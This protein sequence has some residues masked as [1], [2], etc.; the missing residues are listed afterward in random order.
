MKKNTVL[1][2]H[3]V[4]KLLVAIVLVLCS[5]STYAISVTFR[6][7]MAY[8]IKNGTFHP[9]TDKVYV[10]G[11]FNSWTLSNPM[12]QESAG[13]YSTTL[14]LSSSTWYEFK[15]F[16]DAAGF[17]NSGWEANVGA[18]RDNRIMSIVKNE[19]VDLG[20]V[21][22]NN[23]NLELRKSGSYYDF[24]CADPD[25][26]YIG[27]YAS[28]LDENVPRIVNVLETTLTSKVK[29]WIYPDRKSFM[30]AYGSPV[31]PDWVGGTAFGHSDLV[32]L[33]PRIYSGGKID[34]GLVGHEFAHAIVDCKKHSYV[35]AWL[36]EGAACYYGGEPAAIGLRMDGQIRDLLNNKYHGVKP[37]L[38]SIE[39][40][41]FA[42]ND[43]YPLSTSI[44]DFIINSFGSSKFAQFIVDTD[45]S[46]LGF[47]SKSE[48]Q[49][50]WH[51][52]LDDVYLP[53]TPFVHLKIDM[54]YYISKGW[55]NPATDK[56][57]IGGPFTSWFPYLL[58]NQSNGIYSYTL[59]CVENKSY[60]YKFKISTAGAANGGWE[61]NVGTG[62]NGDRVLQPTTVDQTLPTAM[63]NNTN[64]TLSL[65]SPNGNESFIAGDT[66]S[67]QWKFSTIP[68]IKIEYTTDNGANWSLISASV[69]TANLSINWKVPNTVA[70]SAKVRITDTSNPSVNNVSDQSFSIVE[71]NEVGGPFLPDDHTMALLHFENN[72]MNSSPHTG[73][74]ILYG[75]GSAFENNSPLKSG[76][77][78]NLD[79]DDYVTIPHSQAL[80]LIGDWTLE[81]W[82]KLNEYTEGPYLFYKPGDNDTYL[83]NYSLQIASWWDNVIFGF[84][85]SQNSTRIGLSVPKPELN[86]W[87][88]IAY[89]RDTQK[90]QLKLLLHD[91]NFNLVSSQT[92]SYTETG[93][94]I[95]S[96][97]LEIGRGFKG[98]MDELRISNSIREFRTI[99]ITTPNGGETLVGGSKANIT[100]NC[101]DIANVNLEYSANNGSTWVSVA[102]NLDA[103]TRSYIWTV[104][105]TAAISCKIRIS[106]ANDTTLY[107]DSD[108][109][110]T[111]SNAV[112]LAL[113]KPTGGES[114]KTGSTQT[115]TWNAEGITTCKLEYS[116][117]NGESWQPIS[118][119]I[120]AANRSYSFNVPDVVAYEWKFKISDA[121]N[122]EI[123]SISDGLVVSYN[124]LPQSVPPL[125]SIE[126]PVFNWPLNAYYPPTIPTDNQ[127]INGNVGNACGPTVVANLLRYWEF[128][129]KGTGSRT[130]TDALGCN[131]TADFKN[132]EYKYDRMPK[133]VPYAAVQAEYDAVATLM[134]HSGVAMHN[135]FRSG[136]R[137]GVIDAMENYF[138][139][140]KKAKFLSREDYTPEQWEKI[141]KSE[142]SLGRPLITEGW[143]NIQPNGNHDGHWFFCDGYNAENLYHVKWDYGENSNEYCPLYKFGVY[144]AYNWM[145]VYLE[146]DLKGKKLELTTP[147]GNE[148]W[149]QGTQKTIMW[150]SSNVN[151]LNIEFST[152]NGYDWK[153]L[154]SNVST[155]NGSYT[156]TVPAGISNNC[157]IRITDASDMNI[158]D[159]N[160]ISFSVLDVRDLAFVQSFPAQLQ[161]GCTIPLRWNSKGV[162]QV[163]IDYS[164]NSGSSWTKI[165]DTL[166]TAETYLWKVPDVVSSTCLIKVS[167]KMDNTLHATSDAFSIGDETLTG[168]PFC[169]TENTVALLHFNDNYKNEAIFSEDGLYFNTVSF[170]ENFDLGLDKCIKIDN[171]SSSVFSNIEIPHYEALSL[172]KGWNIELWFKLL[173]WGS[174]SVEYPTLL[175]KPGANYYISPLPNGKKLMAG[176]DYNEGNE[177]VILPNNSVSLNTWYH[178]TF[179]KNPET[180]TLELILHDS[181]LKQVAYATKQYNP[182]H[183]PNTSNDPLR[184]GGFHMGSNCQLNGYVDEVIISRIVEQQDELTV[185]F[186]VDMNYQIT[187]GI[188]NPATDKVYLKGSFNGWSEQNQ[189]LENSGTGV[190]T[191]TITLDPS[192]TY[193]YKYFITSSG[194]ENNGWELNVGTE[195]NSNRV[196]LTGT[197]S[198][199]LATNYFNNMSVS[200]KEY[201]C[202]VS[203]ECYPNPFNNSTTIRFELPK[204]AK[205]TL[206]VYTIF[207][208]LIATLVDEELPAGTHLLEWHA[209][210]LPKGVYYCRLQGGAFT[211]GQKMVFLGG[212]GN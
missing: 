36:N 141:V 185:T 212:N 132:T 171:S 28:Y 128:P 59:P 146:P 207:G 92:L 72:L 209:S 124:D 48:F 44:A 10:G 46:V 201:S 129:R 13:V 3:L 84:Y 12:D 15:F 206:N 45:Y 194:A 161:S 202:N 162:Q 56:V 125:M 153:T 211:A 57:Y 199:E 16:T 83:S 183:I 102:T 93:T 30:L 188:F 189:M 31:G 165:A 1:T 105:S 136:D 148:N 187:N 60:E 18:G 208:K 107:D 109:L 133:S 159:R 63:Y 158:Y 77:S 50:A 65:V 70:S 35:H 86:K 4:Q 166:A 2:A 178:V 137:S 34:E 91:E 179:I 51:K 14:T 23:G 152:N 167:D 181:Q 95:N 205:T 85:F 168:G 169:L 54:G 104:P 24:Y 62:T 174:G 164:T 101:T 26:Q 9:A 99:K 69:N 198:T 170:E 122:P 138:N 94:L 25:T 21:Y 61:E 43:G 87:Y 155:A 157:K 96:K 143:S 210:S 74:G 177:Q 192:T 175:L 71:P 135:Y 97:P 112:T 106:D 58:A 8:Q 140:S 103:K 33:S 38:S 113:T 156:V 29:I 147:A 41:S 163:T 184:I 52:F 120:Q 19:D 53:P 20:K 17:P 119:S 5:L 200:V 149:Q 130:F 182:S 80:N 176:Y 173:S 145:Y 195:G 32:I 108:Q 193:E 151:S 75:Q 37:E 118:N 42:D 123:S 6:V 81:T 100:W 55:F 73:Y 7:D 172:K 131:W 89:I 68:A 110:F 134:Y 64:P 154:A 186:S 22:F 190:Y 79:G 88:H 66:V 117:D 139:Y 114:W 121:S 78:F 204:A 40:W 76:Y 27:R 11:T 196:V 39:S 47:A 203:L 90:S 150:S 49:A 197:T 191:C 67:I 116:T 160:T 111:I 98:Y 144:A 127:I 82:F 180:S 126:Y 142:L 115:I